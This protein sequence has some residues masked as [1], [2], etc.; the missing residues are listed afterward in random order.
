MI[1]RTHHTTRIAPSPTGMFHLGSARTALFNWLAARA[2]DGRFILRIDDTDQTRHSDAAV[3]VIFD[4][5]DWLRLPYDVCVR[6]SD[7][8]SIY[9]KLAD[10]LVSH[11]LARR[12]GAAIRLAVSD[13][14]DFWNDTLAGQIAISAQDRR[15]ISELVLLRSD[16]MPTYHLASVVDDMD[17]G[18]TWVIRGSDHLSNT[19]KHIALWRAVGKLEWSGAAAPMPLWTHLGLITSDGKKISKRDGAA[20]LLDYRD[21]GVDP[22]AMVNWLLRLGWG[23]TI[24][25]KTTRTIDRDRAVRLFLEGGRMRASPANMDPLLLSALDRKYKGMRG[26]AAAALSAS[27]LLPH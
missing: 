25:D 7:R 14:P 3:Q 8:L 19:P 22:D 27:P 2:T 11:G 26:R 16:G 1:D 13:M 18:I 21:S 6:P 12:D 23:P 15:V 4:A 17:L 24:D 9:R 5:L 20:S 10:D